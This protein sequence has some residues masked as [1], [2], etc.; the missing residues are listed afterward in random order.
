MSL[1]QLLNSVVYVKL[2][3]DQLTVREVKSGDEISEPPLL[4][5]TRKPKEAVL[6]YGNKAAELA[7]TQ[8]VDLLN[9]F[10]HPRTLLSDFTVASV[11]LKH[12]VSQ[13]NRSGLFKPAPTIVLHP[14][15]DP[16]GGFTQ[17]E[18]RAMRELAISAG[19]REVILWQ[20]RELGKEELLRLQFTSGGE[21]LN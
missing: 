6:A 18:I 17:I 9:P 13:V 7:S 4:A 3:S 16:E 2:S 14:L 5:I 11:L 21:V 15:I 20:G 12:F 19:A 1:L 8:V 10:K